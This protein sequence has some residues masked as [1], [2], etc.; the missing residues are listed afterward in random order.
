MAHRV[1][2]FN[3]TGIRKGKGYF[4]LSLIYFG[5][6]EMVDIFFPVFKRN[7]YKRLDL[8]YLIGRLI[9]RRT[10]GEFNNLSLSPLMQNQEKPK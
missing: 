4:L 8:H 5:C 10:R 6:F 2:I 9:H 3:G 7:N 1:P